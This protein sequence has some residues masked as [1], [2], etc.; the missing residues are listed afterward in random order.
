MKHLLPVLALLAG[1][2]SSICLGQANQQSDPFNR[3]LSGIKAHQPEAALVRFAQECGIDTLIV[4]PRF[5]VSSG[6][7]WTIVRNLA[8][9]VHDLDS[10]FFTAAEVWVQ[11]SQIVVELWANSDDVG[12]EVRYYDCFTNGRLVQAEVINWDVPLK[13]GSQNAGWGY[14]RRWERTENGVLKD[15]NSQ[16]VDVMEQPITKPRLDADGEKSLHWKPS[17]GPLKEL[18]LPSALLRIT[19]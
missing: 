15:T 18:K 5:A 6:G 8:A 2:G 13:L 17:L 9:G 10:D 1:L 19:E 14:S 7:G 16:F 3:Y 4:Q 12:S 11:G